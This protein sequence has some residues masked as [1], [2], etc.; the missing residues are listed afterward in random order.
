MKKILIISLIL[1]ISIGFLIKPNEYTYAASDIT[2]SYNGSPILLSKDILVDGENVLIPTSELFMMLGIQ[3]HMNDDNL[4]FSIYKSNIFIKMVIDTNSITV[5]GK[6]FDKGYAPHKVNGEIYIP[7][8]V[9]SHLG[10]SNSYDKEKKTLDLTSET[11]TLY[12]SDY[13]VPGYYYVNSSKLNLR[14]QIPDIWYYISEGIYGID[15]DEHFSIGINTAKLPLEMPFEQYFLQSTGQIEQ[16]DE[17]NPTP[18]QPTTPIPQDILPIGET[19]GSNV[20]YRWNTSTE[21]MI[22]YDFYYNWE[23]IVYLFTFKSD[24]SDS[25]YIEETIRNILTSMTV[26]TNFIDTN[27]EHYVEYHNYRELG[28]ALENEIYSNMKV[29]DYISLK[30]SVNTTVK[31]LIATV[32]KNGNSMKLLVPVTDGNFDSMIFT[33]FGLG[34]HDISISL[35]NSDEKPGNTF[36]IAEESDTLLRFSVLNVSFSNIRYKIPSIGIPSNDERIKQLLASYTLTGNSEYTK[37]KELY[38]LFLDTYSYIEKDTQNIWDLF[39]SKKGN[40]RQLNT[41][42]VTWLRNQGISARLKYGYIG[43][44]ADFYSEV[45]I[46]GKWYILDPADDIKNKENSFSNSMN[47]KGKDISIFEKVIEVS[48]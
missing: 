41:M 31:S 7:V 26:T 36:S 37:S 40:D 21:E 11:N 46:N 19:F 25:Q 30:G 39:S 42:L 23:D 13:T 15:R 29:M 10:V 14:F 32:S 22:S 43:E 28:F 17:Q 38:K 9:L 2:L 16:V 12:Y 44:T 5:N 47:S 20:C 45:S 8:D 34:K 18:T 3:S 27:E 33:P 48:Y 24:I 4:S 35:N 6:T 1:I